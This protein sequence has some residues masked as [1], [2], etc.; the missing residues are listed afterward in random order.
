ML[1]S[2]VHWTLSS[3]RA[4]LT[5][6]EFPQ[7]NLWP[8]LFPFWLFVILPFKVCWVFMTGF[9]W[10]WKWIKAT[11][12][13]WLMLLNYISIQVP[14]QIM[15][16]DNLIVRYAI[17]PIIASMMRDMHIN[18]GQKCHRI[19]PESTRLPSDCV[20]DS[21]LCCVRE[22]QLTDRL[23]CPTLCASV[24]RHHLSCFRAIRSLWSLSQNAIFHSL[25]PKA[26]I[27][28]E[29]RVIWFA[30]WDRNCWCTQE[31]AAIPRMH[32]RGCIGPTWTSL[33]V[34][35]SLILGVLRTLHPNQ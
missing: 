22:T 8:N 25:M 12:E 35:S 33:S 5:Q 23:H 16:N 4:E 17:L 29:L 19:G 21:S 15:G 6:G 26:L 18:D 32:T 30:V 3:L 2:N 20:P 24:V 31:K 34:M 7:I 11:L 1:L 28:T 27:C 13:E 14:Q 10:A 9:L